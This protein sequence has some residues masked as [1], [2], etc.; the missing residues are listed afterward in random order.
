LLTCIFERIA[1]AS[2]LACVAFVLFFGLLQFTHDADFSF[3]K[4]VTSNSRLV[5]MIGVVYF[6][7]VKILLSFSV[8]VGWGGG[9]RTATRQCNERALAAAHAALMRAHSSTQLA[10]SRLTAS[11]TI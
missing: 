11:S 8:S 7:V 2:E 5:T 4:Q 9:F 3:L 6:G 10:R 1:L